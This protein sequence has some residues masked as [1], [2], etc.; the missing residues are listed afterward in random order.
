MIPTPLEAVI[1]DMDG[2][3]LDTEA[4]YRTAIFEA[5]AL[6]GHEMADAL[7]RSFIG[8]PKETSAALMKAHFGPDFPLQDYYRHCHAAFERLSETGVP[9]K[10]GARDLLVFLKERGVPRGVATSSDRAPAEDHLERAGVRDLLDVVVARTDVAVGKPHPE[11]FLAAAGRLGA[12]P[13]RCL[14]LEDSYNGVRAASAAGMA[15]IMVPDMLAPTD[16]IRSLCVGVLDSLG[17]VLDALENT[18]RD[19]A[20]E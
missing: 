10:P 9:L 14:A 7:H 19:L 8:T 20:I 15:T 5:C 12:N 2:L 6:V 17:Q 16:E 18:R 13:T 11:T 4:L 1:F 3:L